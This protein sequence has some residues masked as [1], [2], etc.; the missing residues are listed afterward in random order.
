VAAILAD[1]VAFWHDQDG[2]ANPAQEI[3]TALRPAMATLPNSM[4]MVATT[5]YSRKGIVYSTFRR[6]WAKDGDPILIW[7]A[8]TR[9]MN[10]TVSQAVVDEAIELD[11]ASAASEFGAE[12]RTDVE[13]YISREVVDACVVPGRFELPRVAGAAY[14]AFVDPSGGSS[15][16]MTLAVAHFDHRTK[17]VILD[18]VRE[19]RPPFSPEDVCLEFVALL[20]SYGVKR[21][22]GDRYAGE[23]PRE[24]FRALGIHYDPCEKPK[25]QLYVDLLPL[26]NSGRAELL[27][28]ARLA[29]QLCGL[30]RRTARGG[31]DSIDHAV[32]GHDD[33][34]NAAAGCLV[35]AAA[36]GA[37][38]IVISQATMRWA[39]IPACP[40]A[41][42]QP[43]YRARLRY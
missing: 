27:D 38:R 39:S 18:A 8:P 4:L 9:A 12:F 40:A 2:G 43:G 15:D 17:H 22:Q 42:L 16:A 36:G 25:S 11:P 28:H 41:F 26:L 37:R 7:K 34:A 5:P 33:L 10:S 31:R 20:R 32:G 6:H 23:W 14:C 19:R 24:R 1:E 30:E 3:F 29:A 21:V 35:L 13:T